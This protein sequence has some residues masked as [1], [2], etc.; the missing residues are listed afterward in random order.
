MQFSYTYWHLI[1][2]YDSN[3]E[4]NGKYAGTQGIDTNKPYCQFCVSEKLEWTGKWCWSYFIVSTNSPFPYSVF[5]IELMCWVLNLLLGIELTLGALN[6]LL[7]ICLTSLHLCFV[8]VR[9]NGSGDSMF[10]N[11]Y[12]ESLNNFAAACPQVGSVER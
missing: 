6:F 2:G 11:D 7:D 9:F 12:F 10:L 4:R 8:G 1:S 3:K 5:V